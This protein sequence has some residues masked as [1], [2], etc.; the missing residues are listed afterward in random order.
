MRN[1]E[2]SATRSCVTAPTPV[3][4]VPT[5]KAI[6]T[7]PVTAS[8]RRWIATTAHLLVFGTGNQINALGSCW[9]VTVQGSSN[10]I[11]A[12]NVVNDITVYGFDQTVFYKSGAPFVSD[13][14]R[15]LGMTNRIDRVARV[16]RGRF[17]IAAASVAALALAGCGSESK[18]TNTPTATAGSIGRA[19]RDR[20]HH[21]LRVVRYDRRC[22]LRRR[23]VAQRGRFQQQADHQ[24]HLRQRE[25]RRCRQHDHLRTRSTRNYPSS[26]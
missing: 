25:H 23:K 21:Q 15:E 20:Q 14:G 22:R 13:R 10:M 8:S 17:V 7:S 18:D 5:S 24:G 9:A 3:S 6:P 11:V 12:D 4:S 16:M 2:S 19:G 26:A 1:R